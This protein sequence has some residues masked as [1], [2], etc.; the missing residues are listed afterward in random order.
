LQTIDG[1]ACETR[2]VLDDPFAGIA[3]AVAEAEPDI[4]LLGPHRRQVLRD[5]FVDTTAERTIRTVTCPILMVN[6]PPVGAYRR[7]LLTTD[8]SEVSERAL[9]TTVALDIAR[10]AEVSVLHV[11]DAPA[12]QLLMSQTMTK[13]EM[14][15]CVDDQ[16]MEVSHSLAN[17]LER[18][19]L[20]AIRRDLRVEGTSTAG[21]IL[22]AARAEVAD[23]VVVGTRGR[24]GIPRFLL[25]SVAEA[26]LRR[27]TRDVLAV[28]S[29]RND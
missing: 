4:L 6:G 21:E 25:G 8:L 23:L 18:L 28:P 10:A 13:R 15:A 1:I 27:S 12:S 3:R 22:K 9:M 7:V 5:V 24:S 29:S 26:V 16:R 19:G 17:F 14:A 20:S 2:I 11:F